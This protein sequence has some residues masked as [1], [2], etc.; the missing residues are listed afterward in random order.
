[1]HAVSQLQAF[2]PQSNVARLHTIDYPQSFSTSPVCCIDTME[3]MLI[4]IPK[5]LFEDGLEESRSTSH[6]LK[7]HGTKRK[8]NVLSREQ[9][10][11]TFVTRAR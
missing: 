7:L 6:N 8:V 1:M 9:E 2:C 3:D 11:G 4:C 5:L 10:G